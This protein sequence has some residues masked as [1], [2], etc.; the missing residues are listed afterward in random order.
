M[1]ALMRAL[2]TVSVMA[3]VAGGDIPCGGEYQWAAE[4]L[5]HPPAQAVDITT[6]EAIEG[7]KSVSMAGA[8]RLGPRR[9]R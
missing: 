2:M 1:R 8:R 9:R 3:T 6:R 4:N 5:F 7:G